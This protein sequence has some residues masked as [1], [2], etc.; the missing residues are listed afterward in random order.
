[1]A[2]F[3]IASAATNRAKSVR[4]RMLSPDSWTVRVW[5][6]MGWHWS[7]I[8]G[9]VSLHED[10]DGKFW[11]M[12]SYDEDDAGVGVSAW[13]NPDT[14]SMDKILRESDI[15]AD[16]Q[17]AVDEAVKLVRE[18]LERVDASYGLARKAS[19]PAFTVIGQ[20]DDGET[21]VDHCWARN[22]DD[23][24]RQS[25]SDRDCDPI[26]LTIVGVFHGHLVDVCN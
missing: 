23:A 10:L 6:N 15:L 3:D 21:F 22:R 17:E 24:V 2:S 4:A 12:V 18:Y 1:M 11:A 26:E 16:P 25:C 8:C 5:E 13:T 9:N 20:Y 14:P 19:M 7:L